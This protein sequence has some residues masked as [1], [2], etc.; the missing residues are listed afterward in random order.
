M[1]LGYFVPEFPGQTHIF[2]WREIRKLE[3]LGFAVAPISTRRPPD[4]LVVHRWSQE[5]I[6]RTSYLAP[7]A[8]RDLIEAM[9]RLP[10][11]PAALREALRRDGARAAAEALKFYPFAAK[12]RRLCADQGI[13]HLHV[14]S[15]G[16]AALVAASARLIGG[17]PY[18]LTLHNPLAVFGPHQRFK[19]SGAAF[20]T[21]ITKALRDEVESTL[22][23][24]APARVAVQS[25]GVD[26]A[27]FARAAPYEPAAPRGP[28]RVF[29]CARLNPA[30][31][32]L[33]TIA[34]IDLLRRRGVDA[35]LEIAGEDDQGGAGFRGAVAAEIARLDLGDAVTLLGA[36]D[37]ETVIAKLSAAHIF[38]LASDSEP[39]G[40][41]YME[42][43]SCEVPTIGTAAG[44][45]P[46]L[47]VSGEHGLLAPPKSPEAIAE[48]IERI[49]HDPD[50]A[51]RLGAAGRRRVAERFSADRGAATLRDLLAVDP[52]PAPTKMPAAPG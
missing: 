38:V 19:W 2:F 30:K 3:A 25:M 46:E 48:A 1:K 12:L 47:I 45:V 35:H 41:A 18:S 15:C 17:P 23:D 31:G 36:V 22:P 20:A 26:I 9:R 50:L 5:A 7:L 27:K 29:S 11:A 16:R 42:A 13:D 8:P 33:H 21:V 39:L 4:R 49:L 28:V 34:A 24:A 32:H 51:R 52:D 43:M 14:G 6:A 37:E 10:A 44:G 40:V